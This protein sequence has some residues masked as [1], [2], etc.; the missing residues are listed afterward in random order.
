NEIQTVVTIRVHGSL[1]Y[2]AQCATGDEAIQ[3]ER[4]ILPT[5]SRFHSCLQFVTLCHRDEVHRD[6]SSVFCISIATVIGPT[7]PGTGVIHEAR[8][9]AAAKSTSPQSDPS[10]QRL[11]PTSMTMAPGLIQSPRTMP[12][13]P[14]ATTSRSA[15]PTWRAR[16]W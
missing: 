8:S 14:T 4:L 13:L 16:S 9:A 5:A 15:S 12:G 1:P 2:S 11:M 7:P 10:S 3:L 6:A